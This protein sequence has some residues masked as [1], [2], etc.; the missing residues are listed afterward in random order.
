MLQHTNVID[1]IEIG[2][3]N[4][5]NSFCSSSD[6]HST[7]IIQHLANCWSLTISGFGFF[8]PFQ[9]RFLWSSLKCTRRNYN[10]SKQSYK[11]LLILLTRIWWW[12]I[13]H[14]GYTSLTLTTAANY[15]LKPCFWKQGTDSARISDVAWLAS[16]D[17]YVKL[18]WWTDKAHQVN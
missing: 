15:C 11:K 3:L 2:C 1:C 13:Y 17:A 12:S 18:K 4:M 7:G 10:S 5:G 16:H 6:Q 8:N 14:R 9:M